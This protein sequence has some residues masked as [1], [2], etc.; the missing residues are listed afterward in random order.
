MKNNLLILAAAAALTAIS[1]SPARAM[2]IDFTYTQTGESDTYG[3]AVPPSITAAYGQID[4][5]GG[6]AISGSLA[7]TAGPDVGSYIL[8]P[9]TGNDGNFVYDNV[10]Y[11]PGLVNGGFLDS[12]AGLLWSMSGTAGNSPEM[13]MWYNVAYQAYIG[14]PPDTYS[15]WGVPPTYN[16]E[17]YGT[18]VLTQVPD[19]G[20]TVSM[21]GL[22]VGFCGL[23][24][25]KMKKLA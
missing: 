4:V 12:T 11:Y 24:A 22:A 20:M 19:G 16:P 18:V 8:V 6:V 17:S 3:N 7:V 25:R 2:L 1:T 15:L 14:D 5:V 10:V 9:G 13:N 23:F 21:L